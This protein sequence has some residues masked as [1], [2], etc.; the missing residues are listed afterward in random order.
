MDPAFAGGRELELLPVIRAISRVTSS[1]TMSG[2]LRSSQS[3]SIGL[4]ISRTAAPSGVVGR[5]RPPPAALAQRGERGERLAA[6][7]GGVVGD[8]A[9]A[10]ADRIA[11]LEH[12]LLGGRRRPRRLGRTRA[13]R[14]DAPPGGRPR[15]SPF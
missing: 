11:E 6:G 2:R 12:V 8:Q 5:D 13:A 7:D 9:V 15:R 14:R 3:L 4:S 1:S 10:F